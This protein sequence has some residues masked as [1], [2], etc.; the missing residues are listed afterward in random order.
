[1]D[2]LSIIID[3]VSNRFARLRNFRGCGVELAGRRTSFDHVVV[4][5]DAIV[6]DLL[7]VITK[8]QFSSDVDGSGVV[9]MNGGVDAITLFIQPAQHVRCTGHSGSHDSIVI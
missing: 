1:M 2:T 7:P 5:G 8:A 4:G 6:I 9:W 3:N